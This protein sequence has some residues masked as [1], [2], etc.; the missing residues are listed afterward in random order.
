MNQDEHAPPSL[1]VQALYWFRKFVPPVTLERRGEVRVSLRDSAQPDFEYFVLV[2]LSSMIATLGLLTNSAAVIIGAML[3]AP[4]MSPII[5]LG[6]GSLIGDEKLLKDAASAIIRGAI[7]AVIIS[8]LLTWLNASLPF[9][10]LHDL[11]VE[12]ISRTR[13]SP[14]D[15]LIAL[16]GGLAAAFA[17]AQPSLSAALPGVA[18]ATALMPPLGTIGIG[19][20]M[21]RWDVAGGA[22]LLFVTNA[23]TIA[24]ASMLVFW[25]L[26]FSPGRKDGKRVPRSLTISAIVTLVM[27]LPLSFL[28]FSFFQEASQTRHINTVVAEEVANRGAT[29]TDLEMETNDDGVLLL[30]I[31]LRTPEQL[32]YHDVNLLQEDIAVRLQETVAIVVDQVVAAQLDPLIPPTFTSTPTPATLTPT[33]SST[34]T[35]TTTPLPTSTSTPKPTATSTSTPS[36]ARIQNI[37]SDYDQC[38]ELRQFPGYNRPVIGRVSNRDFVTVLY[39]EKLVDG[40]SWVEIED[41]D[42]RVGWLP[43]VCMNVVT[44]TPTQTPSVA[45]TPSP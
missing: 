3:V 17:L 1:R 19:V 27:L 26:G 32:F 16:A 31:T 13:P 2:V 25:A 22:L 21:G 20:A 44:L 35:S 41:E 10:T 42:E 24:F 14:I 15:L 5:G 23:V 4:L 9:I 39:G 43:Q 29:L 6:L 45:I 38:L 40:L 8:V 36:T 12:V 34:P 11:P 7:I 37:F 30:E 33:A 18:I 28:S